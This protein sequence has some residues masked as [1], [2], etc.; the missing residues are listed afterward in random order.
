MNIKNN[1]G[2]KRINLSK[3]LIT[4]L[5]LLILPFI[6]TAGITPF[7][8]GNLAVLQMAVGTSN[9]TTAS[10]IE[11]KPNMTQA[12]AVYTF[13]IPS[14]GATALRFSGS[15]ATTGYL[16]TSNDGS[17]LC[18]PGVNTA[19]TSGNTNGL[20][21][22]GVG[23]LN[24]MYSY[25]LPTTYTS[26]IGNQ[27]RG[28]TSIDNLN[29]YFA[30]Q[31][32]FYTNG[33]SVASPTGNIRCVKPFGGTVYAFTATATSPSVGILSAASG[34]TLT[35]LNGL[36]NGTTYN[37]DFYLLSSGNNGNTYDILY[38]IAATTAT[39]GTIYK[40][41]LVN[42][43]WVANNYYNTVVGGFGMCAATNGTG[44]YL[45]ITTGLGS[46]VNNTVVRLTDVAGY[47][48]NINITT[49]N[50][51]TLFTAT[52]STIL[53]G[54]SFAPQMNTPVL[55]TGTTTNINIISATCAGKI[56]SDGGSSIIQRGICYDTTA[57]P[58]VTKNILL[59]TGTLGAFSANL[60]GLN[61]NT[62]YHYRTFAQ[63]TT[64]ISY[65]ADST[66]TT[67]TSY[68]P[69]KLVIIAIN[70]SRTISANT[71]FNIIIQAQDIQ[72]IPKNT[73]TDI[74]VVLTSND[75]IG[76][77]TSGYITAGTNGVI[78]QGVTLKAGYN[79]TITASDSANVLAAA[80]SSPFT[81]LEAASQLVIN[82]LQSTAFTNQT[83]TTFTVRAL[84]T[85]NTLDSNFIGNIQ[86]NASIIGSGNMFGTST[87][88]AL[89][90]I[91][92]FNNI[93]FD[94]PG[95]CQ[96]SA[97]TYGLPESANNSLIIYPAP[98]MLE[99]VV[100]KYIGCKSGAAANT[101]RT[102]ISICIQLK[103]LQPDTI[104]DLR[105][106][107]GLISDTN[108]ASGA[109]NT[110]DGGA[111][112]TNV[113]SQAFSTD[114]N[115]NSQPIWVL[116]STTSNATRFDAGQVHNVRVGYTK[117]GGTIP[118]AP[119]FIGT[120]TITALDISKIA[121]TTTTA[122]DGAFL[123]G[124]VDSIASGKY[125]L[126]FDNTDG[127]GD[128]LST[129]QVRQTIATQASQIDLPRM[130]DSVYMQTGSSIKGDYAVVIPIGI[131]NPNGI[132]RIE[133]RNADNSI[134]S[135]NTSLNGMWPN[136]VNTTTVN[137][138]DSLSI[139]NVTVTLSKKLNV[140]A[141]LQEYFNS[142]TGLMNQTLGINW[143]TGDL[144]KNFSGTTVD[145]VM[146]LIRKTNIT[147]DV[148]SS[149]SIDTVFYGVNLNNNGLIT[150]SLSAAITGY[151]YI[152]I[153]HRN[154]IETW[155]DS[156]DFSTDTVKYDFY[157]YIS[158]FALDNGM[159][160]DGTHA[161]IWGGDVNQNG[162]LESEDATII[163]VA[164]NSEDPTVNNGYVI[165]DIDG[166]GNLDSQD[167]GL[168]YNNAN[169]GANIINPF[170]YL[171]KKK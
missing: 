89:Y 159:L 85:D 20:N 129:Y 80:T 146:V 17:Q 50:N 35:G 78:I 143:E 67:Q 93:Y 26:T 77:T 33:S 83:L 87:K 166:N 133:F 115:G 151:H 66:F 32:G 155:S 141:M 163:Y 16:T 19:T 104:Y 171:K 111:F 96:L 27:T 110:W 59:V 9:N 142:N 119:T 157:N 91:A 88:T 6:S 57:N 102:P 65:G 116:F 51:L 25:T 162:N 168:S 42:G 79:I 154:S 144:F 34:G 29:Y 92:S 107:L 152:E 48:A 55:Q 41:S 60:T 5:M 106:Q 44:A 37:Q 4:F 108:T 122:D 24:N 39:A 11:L 117:T 54:I 139:T 75:S 18:I 130:I 169:I 113:M 2:M 131:N 1:K 7:A 38:V 47:N 147:A 73:P 81:V 124:T 15:A 158:Q 71:P 114:N 98:Q 94:Q 52:G 103:N 165:C 64:G 140:T 99:L 97:L 36:P 14:T 123:K 72:G 95:I 112:S 135:F 69:T 3:V 23:V 145:T 170:S 22:R 149:F 63:N 62:T 134:F 46:T 12:T 31:G 76:G 164:A 13:N 30:D 161:W 10:I 156:V 121:R 61:S 101:E 132:R 153:K 167:Y 105:V 109:G 21:P 86:L 160:Q 137:R 90:G 127:T 125:V 8:T 68:L 100:P 150:I 58:D 84:R 49:A 53:K 120:K 74:K 56:V 40:Y 70:N 45:Y 128:P 138:R 126:L 43:T 28:A 82:G 136:N 148:V 118:S